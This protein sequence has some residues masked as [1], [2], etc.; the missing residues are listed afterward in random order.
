MVGTF[1]FALSPLASH[2]RTKIY[3]PQMSDY[4]SFTVWS[5]ARKDNPSFQDRLNAIV[6]LMDEGETKLLMVNNHP[7]L[8]AYDRRNYRDMERAMLRRDIQL[9]LLT[10]IAAGV[11]ADETYYIYLIQRIDPAQADYSRYP[12]AF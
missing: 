1:D 2:L 11:V 6:T 4:G 5:K 9:E 7:T 3:Y 10:N 8:I 12:R